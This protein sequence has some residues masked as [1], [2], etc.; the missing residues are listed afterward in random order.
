MHAAILTLIA[1]IA[2]AHGQSCVTGRD[3]SLAKPACTQTSFSGYQCT[4]CWPRFSQ[5]AGGGSCYCDASKHYCSR[6]TGQM[7]QCAP[8]SIYNKACQADSDCITRIDNLLGD[9]LINEV[10]FCVNQLCKPCSPALW[11][12]YKVGDANGIYTCD[13]YNKAFSDQNLH[14]STSYPLPKFMFRCASNGDIEVVNATID[15][16]YQYPYGDRSSWTYSTST[17]TGAAAP[18]SGSTTGSSKG[19]NGQSSAAAG[20]LADVLWTAMII[21]AIV[22]FKF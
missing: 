3:C 9:N 15:W 12:Q 13:G 6:T 7:G 20:L 5:L 16:N 11:T 2:F 4:Q 21:A 8:Y 14:Y 18:A 17:I 10:L 1:L 22:I 19:G